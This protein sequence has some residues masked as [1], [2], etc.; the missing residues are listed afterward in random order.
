VKDMVKTPFIPAKLP[1]K[2]DY[3][4]LIKEIGQ[5]NNSIGQFNGLLV[6]IPNPDLLTA[7]SDLFWDKS[8]IPLK[9][10]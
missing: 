7:P 8:R 2:V 6:N 5:A 4:N 3:T 1:P 10:H 9:G